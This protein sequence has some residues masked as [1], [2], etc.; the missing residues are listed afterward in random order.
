MIYKGIY[1]LFYQYNPNGITFG[2][3]VWGHSTSTDLINWTPQPIAIQPQM[4]SNMN[5]SFTGSTTILLPKSYTPAIL[6]TGIT[7]QNLQVQDLALPKNLLD[8]YLKEWTLVPQNPLMYSTPQNQINATSFRDP[9]T[10]WIMPD[11]KWRVVVGSKKDRLGLALLFT[12]KDFINWKFSDQPLYSYQNTGMWECPDFFPVYINGS[13]IGAETSTF[14]P[15]VKHVLKVSLDDNKH[16]IYTIG[17][18]DITSDGYTP[19]VGFEN[20]SSLRYDYGKYYASKTFFDDR[21]RRRILLGWINESSSLEDDM[22][23]GWAGIHVSLL[24]SE[25]SSHAYMYK[26]V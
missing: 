25:C 19:D 8:P 21:T 3:P 16:D 23:K 7:P 6:F 17:T 12:S 4:I 2:I 24:F 1:H 18:Y 14:G 26:F 20:E 10:A 11:G 13:P 22:Q 9:S 5:G 15:I